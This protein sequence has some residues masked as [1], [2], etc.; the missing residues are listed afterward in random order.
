MEERR[1]FTK[2]LVKTYMDSNG[3]KRCTGIKDDLK[4]S[5]LH[6][7]LARMRINGFCAL[8]HAMSQ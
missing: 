4:A 3:I 8:K 7:S 6:Q 1:S 2:T 5:Q